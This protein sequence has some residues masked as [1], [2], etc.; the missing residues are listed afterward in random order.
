MPGLKVGGLQE[1]QVM[2][3]NDYW[4]SWFFTCEFP[5]GA[6][7][8]LFTTALWFMSLQFA[9]PYRYGS[10]VHVAARG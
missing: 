8:L 10:L 6:F 7:S 1:V 4:L 5:L 2:L 3:S 9:S